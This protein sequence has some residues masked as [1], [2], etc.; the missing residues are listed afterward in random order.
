MI[1]D[2]AV[3]VDGRRSAPCSLEQTRQ[4][5]RERGGFAWV[6]LH[7]PTG[8]EFDS[9][10]DAFGLR[11]LAVKDAIKAHQRP[12]VERYD[13]SLFV[14]LKAAR[15]VEETETVEFGEIHTFVGPD[16]VVTVRYG[17]GSELAD[18]RRQ[19]EGETK[20][21]GRGPRRS[22]TPSWTAWS[23]TTAPW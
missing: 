18:V 8:E 21:L 23:S 19:L 4:A 20:L 14:V 13:D 12:K 22:C 17:G 11:E 7:E 16:F 1:V 10:V 3:Y 2:N 5:Y 15:Y 9:V 6:G